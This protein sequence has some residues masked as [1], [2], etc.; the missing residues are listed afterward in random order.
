M[1]Q[2][3]NV[4]AK[5]LDGAKVGN[6]R[7][8]PILLTDCGK[9]LQEENRYIREKA[10]GKW[11]D[12]RYVGRFGDQ[13]EKVEA[14]ML[15]Y[16]KDLSDFFSYQEW[17]GTYLLAGKPASVLRTYRKHL[18]DGA[19]TRVGRAVAE[20]TRVRRSSIAEDFTHWLQANGSIDVV[21]I[22]KAA[23]S[24]FLQNRE[25]PRSSLKT[26][27]RPKGARQDPEDLNVPKRAGIDA[28]LAE[29]HRTSGLARKTACGGIIALGLRIEEA[30]RFRANQLPKVVSGSKFERVKIFYGAKGGRSVGDAERKG[31]LRRVLVLREDLE[32]LLRY[33]DGPR[34]E[35]LAR[36]REKNP[37]Q[38]VPM[39]LFLDEKTGRPLTPDT[40]YR[41]WRGCQGPIETGWSPHLGRHVY[42]MRLLL[43]YLQIEEQGY[44]FLASRGSR[45]DGKVESLLAVI[46]QPSL[47]HNNPK[48][49]KL[50]LRMFARMVGHEGFAAA[51]ADHLS[52][53]D[54]L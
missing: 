50:Y 10:C 27:T 23:E 22:D 47:G 13:K 29:V 33:R 45:A 35:A 48:T 28:W 54:Q 17:R 44:R 15:A 38:S 21:E 5:D 31:K 52:D 24:G 51:Y 20:S 37:D 49:T 19:W 41:A 1:A 53:A 25:K 34:R 11:S 36:F 7:P 6:H 3:I 42:A 46:V 30:A 18:K 4:T 26:R 8:L 39:E 14:T 2:V 40:I 32:T 43:A 16:A 12:G 9:Y